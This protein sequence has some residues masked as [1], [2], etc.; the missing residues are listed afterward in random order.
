VVFADPVFHRDDDRLRQAAISE[1]GALNPSPEGSARQL[2]LTNSGLRLP[3]LRF[4]REEAKAITELSPG[5]V[6]ARL[7]FDA[8]R[9]AAAGS[10]TRDA[11]IVHFATHTFINSLRP[12]LSGIVLSLFD[13][14]GRAQE[15]FLRLH[16][17][18]NLEMR[19]ELVVLSSCESGLG[20]EVKGEGLIGFT[21]AFYYAGASRVLAT[22]WKVNDEPTAEF[23]RRFYHAL[24]ARKMSPAAALRTAQASMAMSKD[25]RWRA[26]YSWAG[27]VLYG[28]WR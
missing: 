21:R 13:K 5:R 9:S 17:I 4:T 20:K 28:D 24:L 2:L 14:R 25:P 16:D 23:M 15:G 1:P 27:F 26:P 3:R 12:E 7:D 22:L 18:Y 8:S 19:A 6:T 11:G 10:L